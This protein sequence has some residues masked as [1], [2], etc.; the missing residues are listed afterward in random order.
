MA[1]EPVSVRRETNN[2]GTRDSF[3]ICE[4]P[5]I[6]DIGLPGVAALASVATVADS[7]KPHN[8]GRLHR[9]PK[10]SPSSYVY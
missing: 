3:F 10:F 6:R 8:P 5:C 2:I 1:K 9:S 4:S 7:P